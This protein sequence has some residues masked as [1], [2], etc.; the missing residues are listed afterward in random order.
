MKKFHHTIYEVNIMKKKGKVMLAITASALRAG[1]WMW[2]TQK[3][4]DTM[5]DMKKGIK[6]V[7]SSVANSIEG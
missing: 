6:K 1:A 5:E 7:A 2:Y 3:N 4:P